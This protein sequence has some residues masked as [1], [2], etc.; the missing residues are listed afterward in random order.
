MVAC[1]ALHSA[2]R[3]GTC[4]SVISVIVPGSAT[5]GVAGVQRNR[6]VAMARTAPFTFHVSDEH[7]HWP[8]PPWRYQLAVVLVILVALGLMTFAAH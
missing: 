4:Y 6:E 1:D 5:P 3:H 8:E 7:R 2:P